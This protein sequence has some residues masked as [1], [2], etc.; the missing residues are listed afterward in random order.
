MLASSFS[1]YIGGVERHL[2][3]LS[4]ELTNRGHA[5]TVLAPRT[6]P[7]LP[8]EEWNTGIRILRFPQSKVPHTQ[9]PGVWF[10]MLSRLSLLSGSDVIHVHDQGAF[11]AWFLPF[12]FLFSWKPVFITFHGH[13]GRFPLSRRH[14]YARKVP[15]AL[16]R[17]NICVGHFLEKWYGTRSDAITYGAVE[18]PRNHPP[19][20]NDRHIVYVGRL[21]EDAGILTYM[22]ALR[23]LS[24][25][26]QGAW[27]LSICGD[28][29]LRS[30]VEAFAREHSLDVEFLGVVRDLVP[31]IQHSRF[32]FTSGYLAILEAMICRRL[33]FSVYENPLKRDYL[34]MFPGAEER[35]M[36]SGSPADLAGK[37]EGVLAHPDQEESRVEEAFR[38]AEQQTWGH[39]ADTCLELYERR[40]LFGKKGTFDA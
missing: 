7:P 37:L 22:Q 19:P 34:E 18:K 8:R 4:R 6:E 30:R 14:R 28:G 1:P 32:V 10:W 13:E 27:K 20:E 16:T 35:M 26:R 15:E 17:G 2:L 29:S 21:E 39:L 36:I 33:V 5:V 24:E 23:L 31:W 25:T 3:G 40:V 11:L 12:R 9:K 38:F